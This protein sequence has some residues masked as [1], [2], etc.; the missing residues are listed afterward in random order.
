MA[1]ALIVS[2]II[3]SVN[4]QYFSWMKQQLVLM[5]KQTNSFKKWSEHNS[6]TYIFL[7]S[8][9]SHNHSPQIEHNHLL[10]QD[11]SPW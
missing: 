8:D 1:R 6:K 4:H 11:S 2:D 5:R 9:N 10:R 3:F 7:Y